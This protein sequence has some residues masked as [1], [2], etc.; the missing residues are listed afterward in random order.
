MTGNTIRV[1]LA[2]DHILVRQGMKSLLDNLGGIEVV[3]EAEDGRE[4]LRLI[5]KLRPSLVIMDIAMPRLNGLDTTARAVK[6]IPGLRIIMLSMHANK[7]YVVEAMRAGASGYLLKNCEIAELERGIRTVMNGG[8]YLTPTVSWG[9]IEELLGDT[10]RPGLDDPPL[11][12][13]QREILQLV[14]EGHSS[15]IIAEMLNL[16]TKTVDGH[17]AEIMSRL[18]IHDVTGLVRYAIKM[19]FISPEV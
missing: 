5:R 14:A 8:K 16:S 4:A 7:R 19:G 13:R 15:R 11:T 9:V 18:N 6:E 2:D 1:I 3:G 17:R 12:L 10:G